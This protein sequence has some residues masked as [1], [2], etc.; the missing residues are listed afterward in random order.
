M[1]NCCLSLQSTLGFRLSPQVPSRL[2]RKWVVPYFYVFFI[3]YPATYCWYNGLCD[4]Q[5]QVRFLCRI[6]SLVHHCSARYPCA[7][8]PRR[9]VVLALP[10]ITLCLLQ[11]CA[12]E[13]CARAS[14]AA[15]NHCISLMSVLFHFCMVI[16]GFIVLD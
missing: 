10:S 6:H 5:C 15:M 12:C 1:Y 4:L 16:V 11:P 9:D 8:G 13:A 3:F 2:L 7:L 14:Q